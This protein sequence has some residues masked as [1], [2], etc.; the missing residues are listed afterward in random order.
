MKIL[1][2]SL[3]GGVG[4]SSIASNFA[5]YQNAT[6]VTND[7]V[8]PSK[9]QANQIRHSLKR[10]PYEFH[11][12]KNVVFDFGAM[13]T[14]IDPKVSHAVTFCDVCVIPTLTDERSLAATIETYKLIEPSD[15]RIVILIN[16]YSNG[17]KHAEAREYLM[18]ALDMPVI[19]SIRTTTLFERV[20]K[21][22]EQ[23]FQNINNDMGEYQLNKTRITHEQ[24]YD[25]IIA[26]G[27]LI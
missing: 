27:E 23:W 13:S 4:K 5:T 25:R 16:N 15:I 22:G 19:F 3:K 21:H 10:V 6:Y 20:A 24:V 8:V 14:N 7:L 17:K 26:Y 11:H 2:C 12:L 1:F 18:E 9:S